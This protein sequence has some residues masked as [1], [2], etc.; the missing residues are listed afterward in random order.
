MVQEIGTA[1]VM[2]LLGSVL[3]Y[4]STRWSKTLAK[5]NCLE[6]GMQSILR[7][8]MTQMHRYYKD[9]K[10]PIPQQEVDSFEQMFSAYKQLGGNG[11][12]DDIRKIIVEVMPHENH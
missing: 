11:Y 12:V 3:T 1:I 10:K 6:F 7:D 5:I 8:R 9:K 4:F 2:F